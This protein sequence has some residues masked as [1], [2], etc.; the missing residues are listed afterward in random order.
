M[1]LGALY[2]GSLSARF[3]NS[4]GRLTI[5]PVRG[6]MQAAMQTDPQTISPIISRR[7]FTV[8]WGH[9]DPAGI[10]YNPRFFEYFDWGSW[11]LFELALGVKP[12][13]LYGVYGIIGIPLVDAGARFIAPAKFGDVVELTSQV[14]AFRRSSFDVAHKLFVHGT[15]AIEGHETRVWAARDPSNPDKIKAKPIPP[16]VMAKFQIA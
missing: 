1:I 2:S 7:Q 16:E 3:S 9:C 5:A 15:L 4:P 13:D 12:H 8:E 14:S 10:V 11:N 6:D